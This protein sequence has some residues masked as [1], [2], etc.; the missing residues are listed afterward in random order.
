MKKAPFG[1]WSFFKL[2]PGTGCRAPTRVDGAEGRGWV[3]ARGGGVF[4]GRRKPG[5]RVC[6]CRSGCRRREGAR[7]AGSAIASALIPRDQGF[8]DV[9]DGH[10][11]RLCAIRSSIFFGGGEEIAS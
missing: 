3:G 11:N 5:R 10:L 7:L 6:G 2:S 9:D 1:A 4:R 8:A